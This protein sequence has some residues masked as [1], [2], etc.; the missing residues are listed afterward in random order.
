[1]RKRT[2][3]ARDQTTITFE[4]GGDTV[5]VPLARQ[6]FEEMTT[7]LFDRTRFTVM[8]LLQDAK[9]KWSDIT[10][11]L[12][13]GGSTR[14]PMVQRMLEEVS[15]K[16]CDRSLSADEAVAH[17]AAVYAGLLTSSAVGTAPQLS[18]RNVNSHNLGVLA[19]EKAT[20]VSAIEL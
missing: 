8:N 10:R 19:K 17:G 9:L 5:R 18:V 7:D 12:L 2:L 1:M 16:K 6:Q 14:M 15:G 13:V 4:Y 20:A 11:L 3:S